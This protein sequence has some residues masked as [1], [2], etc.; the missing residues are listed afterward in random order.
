MLFRS[1]AILFFGL[2]TAQVGINTANPKATFHIDGGKDNPSNS[3]NPTIIQQAN[4]FVV[5]SNGNVGIATIAPSEKLEVN[6]KTKINDLPL[7]GTAGFTATRTLV[8]SDNGIVGII[9]GLPPSAYNGYQMTSLIGYNVNNISLGNYNYNQ[10]VSSNCVRY[11]GDYYASPNSNHCY[12]SG[13]TVFPADYTFT[14]DKKSNNAE[15]YIRMNIDYV[16]QFQ[17]RTGNL[18][19][20]GFYFLY[21]VVVTINNI[22][23]KNFPIY[24]NISGN[25]QGFIYDSKLITADLSG[26]NLNPTNNVGALASKL[27]SRDRKSTRLNSSHWE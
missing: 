13:S 1:P 23:I 10:L 27:S 9:N 18:I 22:E 25:G 3:D 14:F 24:T 5:T 7:N 15:K 4:D 20:T 16:H 12:V 6:G 26:I 2:F 17:S 8:A 19:R 21:Y 11:M